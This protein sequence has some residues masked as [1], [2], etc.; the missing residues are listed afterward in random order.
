MR[1][2]ATIQIIKELLPI[3][4]AGSIELATFENIG[5]KCVVKKEEFKPGDKAIYFEIDSL[6]PLTSDFEFLA[7]GNKPKRIALENGTIV[8][9]Y[10]L[11]TIKLRGQLSQGLAL[12]ISILSSFHK[13]RDSFGMPLI[14]PEYK[15]WEEGKDVSEYIGVYKYEIPEVKIAP[16]SSKNP[17]VNFLLKF[18]FFRK[19]LLPEKTSRE[20]P[21]FIPKTDETRIQ[22]CWKTIEKYKDLEWYSAIKFD[23]SSMTVAKFHSDEL[24]V[25][26]RNL[27]VGTLTNQKPTLIQS[28][29]SKVKVVKEDSNHFVETAK[30]LD[31]L[32]KVP[33]GYALQGELFGEG[34]QKNPHKIV[35]KTFKVFNVYNIEEGQFLNYHDAIDFV[36]NI[37]LTFVDSQVFGTLGGKTMDD[38]L[39]LA[40]QT[41]LE[42]LVFRPTKETYDE[43]FGRVSFK[44]ISN[45]Y[46]V[47]HDA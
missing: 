17:F 4:G 25:A 5:W 22:T 15:E 40:D 14:L 21:S 20:F 24:V 1:Q 45:N 34:I 28:I 33:L 6:L 46:L 8:E 43:K 39:E 27:T 12:P 10:R 2:L 19:L 41:K 37:G 26:S 16:P 18:K 23:G 35:S 3:Q 9:G 32:N 38:L 47:K 7:K 42:G 11:K 30:K 29:F 13:S 31:L 36:K 44:V